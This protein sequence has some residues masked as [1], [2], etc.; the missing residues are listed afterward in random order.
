MPSENITQTYLEMATTAGKSE[1]EAIKEICE[2]IGLKF[3]SSYPTQWK[4]GSRP[5]PPKAVKEM[6][7]RAAIYAAKKAG[8]STTT[9]KAEK[10][11]IMLSPATK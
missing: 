10:M 8:I 2:T 1:R 7:Q 6:Q 3:S 11:A 9:E 4:N 5:T